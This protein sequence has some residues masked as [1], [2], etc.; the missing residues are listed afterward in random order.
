MDEVRFP[1]KVDKLSVLALAFQV[2]V[3]HRLFKNQLLRRTSSR[4]CTLLVA[5][6][7]SALAIK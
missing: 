5:I 6:S 7:A 4:Y 1:A 2:K 3:Q